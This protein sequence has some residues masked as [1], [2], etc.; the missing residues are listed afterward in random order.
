MPQLF[1]SIFKFFGIL[2][3]MRILAQHILFVFLLICF[4][5]ADLAAQSVI[6]PKQID[7]GLRGILY[8]EETCFD[9][10]I[11]SNGFYI[12]AN[13]GKIMTYYKTRYY[14][15]G[16]GVL[17]HP[18]EFR[19]PVNFQSGTALIKTSSAFTFG[20]RNNLLVLRGGMGEKRYFSEKAKRKGVA[21]GV[22]YEGGAS[23]GILKP[24]YLEI[25]RVEPGG[26]KDVVSTEKYSEENRDFFLDE[27]RILGSTNF[28]KGINEVSIVP[29]FHAKIA[30]HFSMGA[31]DEYVKA[32]EVGLMLD[33][34]FRKVPI[35]ILER[36]QSLFFNAFIS[37]Q[38]GK[39]R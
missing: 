19:Q 21:V 7:Y 31:F 1:F 11:H 33:G 38:F 24:Y 35:M 30:M 29:G 32:V 2:T 22:S 9:A 3:T 36:D 16:L 25:S 13:F 17:K 6:Q 23:L 14:H 37:V 28:F 34:Y 8:K 15:L 4:C 10:A 27:N 39:R 26:V 20:K 18:K 5:S 12:G